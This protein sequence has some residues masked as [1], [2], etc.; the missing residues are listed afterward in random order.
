[1]CW[2]V[3]GGKGRYG[4]KCWGVRSVGKYEEVF[5]CG[6][7]GKVRRDVGDGGRCGKC[8][9]GVGKSIS[10]VGKGVER[11]LVWVNV[12]GGG[13]GGEVWEEMWNNMGKCGEKGGVTIWDPNSTHPTP[14]P[15]FL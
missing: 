10:G 14:D 11:V 3:E 9:W 7:C 13:G 15:N 4:K 12:R 5:G 6:E 2:G 1:M 8:G